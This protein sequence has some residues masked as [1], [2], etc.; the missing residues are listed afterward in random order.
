MSSQFLQI[1]EI[2][3]IIKNKNLLDC[4][5]FGQIIHERNN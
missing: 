5:Y 2:E 1:A 4:W 3:L